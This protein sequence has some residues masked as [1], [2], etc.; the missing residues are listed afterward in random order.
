MEPRRTR[1][2]RD[3]QHGKISGVCSGLADYTGV[4]TVWIRLGMVVLFLTLGWPI[5]AYFVIAWATPV[6]PYDL[7]AGPDEQRFWQG[8]R[9][10]PSRSA[11]EVRASFRDLDRRLADIEL[12]YTSRNKRLE[13]EIEALR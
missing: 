6:K 13:D 5:L 3:K 2:Y 7:Y 10:N 9:A 4:D 11:R 12:F 8:V 1:F